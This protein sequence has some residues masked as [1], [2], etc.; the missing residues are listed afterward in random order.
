MVSRVFYFPAM[1]TANQL[2]A[3]IAT[4]ELG[5]LA[6]LRGLPRAAWVLF[7]GIFLNRFGTFVIPFLTLYMTR[8]GYSPGDAGVA[9]GS[10]GAGTLIACFV[11][12]HLADSIGRRKTIALSMFGG[13]AT[14][15]LLAG[16][17]SRLGLIL[18]T[19]LNG[20]CGE[21]YRP[22]SSAL[23]TD[24]VPPGQRVIAFSTYRM[25]LNAGWA[26]GPATAGFLAN[27]SFFWLFIGDAFTSLLFGIVAWTALPHGVRSATHESGWGIAL[28][29]IA[30]NPQFLQFLA[31]SLF[32]ALVFF[33]ISSTYGLFIAQLGYPP[34][35]Y[36]A[37][38]SLNGLI[39][40]CFELV[41]SNQSRRFDPRRCIAFGYALV[42]VGFGLNVFATGVPMLALAIVILTFG[43]IISI[44]IGAAYIAD[45]APPSMRGRYMGAHGFTW[46]AALIFGPGLGMF[47][48]AQSSTVLWSLC[49]LSGLIGAGIISCKGN[50]E[51]RRDPAS[52]SG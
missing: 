18:L 8:K 9:I 13:A 39:V 20:L 17:E 44:P 11:G 38:I 30:R 43:E 3:T 12:G 48:L 45:L 19:G 36:G 28:R 14:M 47:L 22:A 46:G 37:L 23:L 33:Q 41:V 40:A 24:L 1:N 4:S 35:V 26:F 32:I 52:T 31:A 16:A 15:L 7:L 34:A 51:T 29:S 6:S 21:L 27:H 10:Y 2:T 49:A 5:L 42:A 50:I 25:A